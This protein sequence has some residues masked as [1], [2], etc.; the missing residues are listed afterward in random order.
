MDSEKKLDSQNTW[1]REQPGFADGFGF[2]VKA[3]S[4]LGC[5][6]SGLTTAIT[7]SLFT[8]MGGSAMNKK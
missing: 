3:G 2:G 5:R 6:V 1:Q 8:E 4:R 7:H